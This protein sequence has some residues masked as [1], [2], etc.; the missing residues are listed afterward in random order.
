M[1][2]RTY[3][4]RGDPEKMLRAL[5]AG[6]P[7]GANVMGDSSAGYIGAFG[8]RLVDYSRV[9]KE[10]TVTVHRGAF[11]YSEADIWDGIENGLRGFV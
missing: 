5:Q 6:L 2:T 11:G 1:S 4:I 8:D 7:P 9:G 3:T 10:L